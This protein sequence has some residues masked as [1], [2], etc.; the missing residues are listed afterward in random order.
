MGIGRRQFL[1]LFQGA[2]ATLAINPSSAIAIF[3]DQYVNRKLG[4]AFRKPRDWG[5]SD[6]REMG[7]IK[8]GQILDLN[9]DSEL[10][11][12][13][14]NSSDLPLL[15][16]TKDPLSHKGTRFSPGVNVYLE[17]FEFLNSVSD[18]V[19]I[20]IPP[21]ENA[22]SDIE[23]LASVLKD[24]RVTSPPVSTHVSKC[25]AVD[26]TATF[27]FEHEKIHPTPVRMRT[28]GI[29]QRPA[30]YTIRMYDSPASGSVMRIDYTGFV[31]S[32]TMV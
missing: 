21:L 28:L 32:I 17:R 24:F 11:A 22:I 6:V 4:I 19:E 5:F 9:G 3:D 10:I 12:D 26:Y 16:V 13:I 23:S 25:D 8:A 31:E 1:Q 18:D 14:V 30:F 15:T 27:V 29:Y 20:E 7:Q 2:L